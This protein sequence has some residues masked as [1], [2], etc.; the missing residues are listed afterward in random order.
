VDAAAGRA[1]MDF[2]TRRAH[3]PEAGVLA[4]RAAWLGGCMGTSN[5]L[6][7]FRYGIPVYGTAAHSWVLS[8]CSETESFRQISRCGESVW[9]AAI[10]RGFRARRAPFWTKPACRMP[11]S[12]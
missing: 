7:G 9:T 2:G 8:F 3:T 12:C 1:V 4:A 5:A 11:K 6:A 10:F